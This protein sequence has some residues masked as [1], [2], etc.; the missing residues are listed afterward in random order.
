[1]KQS[2]Y[3]L[4]LGI[5]IPVLLIC[6]TGT[7]IGWTKQE[8]AIEAQ[9]AG[10][11]PKDAESGLGYLLSLVYNRGAAIDLK[12]VTPL[13]DLAL[14]G[15]SEPNRLVPAKRA[16]GSGGCIGVEIKA[17]LKRILRYAYNSQIP[18][19]VVFPNA[20]R[21]SEWYAESDILTRR[22]ELWEELPTLD[23][24]ILLWGREYEENTPDLFA[25]TYYRYNLK[26][27]L[28]LMNHRGKKVLISVSKMPRHSQIGKKAVILDDKNWNYFYSGIEGLNRPFMGGVDTYI[29]DTES[30]LILSETDSGVPTTSAILF[31]WLKAGW[32]GINMV[33]RNHIRKGS[34]RFFV[35]FKQVIESE[36]LSGSDTLIKKV[37]HIKSLSDAEI[38]AQIRSYSFNFER[39]AKNNKYMG[40]KDF[41]RIIVG[42]GYAKVLKRPERVSVL[43]LEC[44]KHQLGKPSLIKLDCR[45]SMAQKSLDDVGA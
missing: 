27:L 11:L 26:R 3:F 8:N 29:Y 7:E 28:I 2:T 34:N 41:A 25:G 39:M 16:S 33:K 10:T 36:A 19:F 30:V 6:L 17:P 42:G 31:K 32:A 22:T 44:L 13:L 38:N 18:A 37:N 5:S 14:N 21:I 9:D 1:M 43:T 20:L 24:P 4:I 23:K 35:G 40:K 12:R 15:D 45:P